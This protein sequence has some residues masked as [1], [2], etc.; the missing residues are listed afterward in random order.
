MWRTIFIAR[1]YVDRLVKSM[2]KDLF[3]D[4]IASCQEII[5]YQNGHIQLKTT[6]IEIPDEELE[7]SQ[8]LFQKIEQLPEH[9]KDQAIRYVDELLRTSVI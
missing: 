3:D 4:L 9:S 6:I 8:L 2:D 1:W 5:D 7:K